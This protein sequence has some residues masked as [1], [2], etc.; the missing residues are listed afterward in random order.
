MDPP[1][2]RSQ[3]PEMCTSF[4][5]AFS[6]KVLGRGKDSGNPTTESDPYRGAKSP[7][8]TPRHQGIG[9]QPT[10]WKLH[11]TSNYCSYWLLRPR[12]DMRCVA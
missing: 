2:P 7:S 10:L 6:G 11:Q 1:G 9:R 8:V 5:R 12:L 4:F 3:K